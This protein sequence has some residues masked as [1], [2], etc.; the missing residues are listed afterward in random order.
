MRLYCSFILILK[1]KINCLYKIEHKLLLVQKKKLYIILVCGLSTT[2]MM[3][4]NNKKKLNLSHSLS[5]GSRK[6]LILTLIFI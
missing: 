5:K 1:Q 6:Q 3:E 2:L 4:Y